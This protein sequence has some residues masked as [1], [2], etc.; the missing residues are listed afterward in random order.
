MAPS[1][2]SLQRIK[3]FS[4][5]IRTLI[6]PISVSTVGGKSSSNYKK[7]MKF[8]NRLKIH[9]QS[10]EQIKSRLCKVVIFQNK[11]LWR[12]FSCVII[13]KEEPSSYELEGKKDLNMEDS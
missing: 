2:T 13:N 6:S 10:L 8:T 3:I 5:S 7:L 11:N 4:R 9:R 12:I 1:R